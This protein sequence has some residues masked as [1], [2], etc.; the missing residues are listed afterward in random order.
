MSTTAA[1]HPDHESC[2]A[3]SI[4]AHTVAPEKADRAAAVLK[5]FAEPLRLRMIALI[6]SAPGGEA[7]VC[8]INELA[9][10][11]GPTV[12]HHLKTLK[13]AGL[14]TSE[15]RGTWVY[16]R[17]AEQYGPAVRALLG[18]LV[19]AAEASARPHAEGL[20]NVDKALDRVAEDLEALFPSLDGTL[21]TRIVRESYASLARG[22][23]I[24]AHLV[25]L[26][27]HFAQQRLEDLRKVHDADAP[28]P[29]QVLF[30][31]VQ[32]AGRSQIAAALLHRYAGDGVVVRSAGSAPAASVH[33]AVRPHLDAIGAGEAA[34]PKPLTDDAVRASD[35]VITMGCGDVCPY[36]PGTRYEDW[37]VGDPALASAEGVA[38]I[39]DDI[40][41]RIRE[42]LADLL[43]DL[44]LPDPT[45][46]THRKA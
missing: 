23:T 34:F 44:H 42:L 10:V 46:F 13:D 12:S 18:A 21:V 26:A 37:Q 11:S 31:C 27:R 35:V 19:P 17:V 45:P 41:R 16:Y 40:D 43:P 9:D 39:V 5:A 8:D 25:P 7:C 30:V 20:E 4:E 36:Y 3:T 32:N 2:V 14:V 29:P 38:E 33:D 28:H 15:R 6:A 1:T 24:R 22:A